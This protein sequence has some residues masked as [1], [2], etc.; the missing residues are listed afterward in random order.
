MIT[1]AVP[2]EG[3]TTV[4]VDLA[5]AYALTGRRVVLIEMDLRRP[6][7]TQHF[8]IDGRRGVTTALTGSDSVSHL[9]VEPFAD[10]PELSVL[11]S[12]VL[13]PNPSELLGSQATVDLL[14]ELREEGALVIIDAPPLNPVADA[15]VLLNVP[16]V[17]GAVIVARVG[18]TT[19][20]EARR[21]RAILDRHVL[22]PLGIVVT[23]LEDPDRYGYATYEQTP[24]AEGVQPG[25][26]PAAE[27]GAT[28]AVSRRTS[29]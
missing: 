21:A 11:P 24:G 6:S 16:G 18:K 14:R 23:G 4:S 26:E 25:H 5:H 3:K 19:R 22:Q 27:A 7:F 13:P 2:G 29:T 1:S 12:G 20:E 15:Q 17:D 9:L 28:R 10:L 8:D